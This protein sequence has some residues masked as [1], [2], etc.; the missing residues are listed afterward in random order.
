[1]CNLSSGEVAAS[2]WDTC[3]L[4]EL[5]Y[6]TTASNL[7][8]VRTEASAAIEQAKLTSGHRQIGKFR[9]RLCV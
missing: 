4:R 5:T 9:I 3:N 6:D 7:N 2:V 8:P 1:M